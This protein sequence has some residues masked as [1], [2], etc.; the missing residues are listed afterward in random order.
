MQTLAVA[1][2]LQ[3]IHYMCFWLSEVPEQCWDPRSSVNS[4][5]SWI[6]H[7]YSLRI[8]FSSLLLCRK[9]LWNFVS[10]I[11]ALLKKELIA[12]S[13]IFPTWRIFISGVQTYVTPLKPL[14]LFT[15]F[16]LDKLFIKVSPCVS[17]EKFLYDLQLIING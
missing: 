15:K 10:A 13:M 14:F 17:F 9:V 7:L 6:T 11:I 16:S 12:T 5:G 8:L 4:T 3:Y 2:C 1:T